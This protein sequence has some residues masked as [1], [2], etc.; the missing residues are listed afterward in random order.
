MRNVAN[1]RPTGNICF[2]LMLYGWI[3]SGALSFHSTLSKEESSYVE[4]ICYGGRGEAT[5]FDTQ[6]TQRI[7]FANISELGGSDLS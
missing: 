6:I 3:A 5:A 4:E 2:V 7:L 1:D